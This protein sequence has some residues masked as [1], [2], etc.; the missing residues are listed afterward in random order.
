MAQSPRPGGGPRSELA[1]RLV[2]F[3]TLPFLAALIPLI[4][5]PFVSRAVSLDDWAAMNVGLSVGAFAAAVGL[6]GWNVLGTPLVAMAGSPADQ[7]ALYARSFYIRFSVVVVASAL[8]AVVAVAIS[9]A[10]SWAP[11]AAFAVASALN[12]I[13]LSWYAV[14]VASPRLVL[15][16]EVIPRTIATALALGVVLLTGQVVWY[17]L[18]LCASVVVGVLA[19]HLDLDRR[20]LPHWP[21]WTTLR[22]DVGDMRHAWGVESV[23]SLYAN[24]PLPIA[25]IVASPVAAAA[26]ASNDKIYRYGILGVGAAGN[27]LQGWVLETRDDVR[28]RRNLIAIVIMAVIAVIGWA[29]LAIFGPLLS[30]WLFGA[31]KQGDPLAFHFFGIAFIGVTMST[32]LI[33]NILIPA[34][35][36]RPVFVVTLIAA[37]GGVASMIVLG[38][39]FGIAGVAAGFAISEIVTLLACVVLTL[40]VGLHHHEV[41]PTVQPSATEK[42]TDEI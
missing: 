38:T 4:A 20:L 18:L 37:A 14:G 23:G 6:V 19:F 26:F 21:G 15:L 16:Y 24:A 33:R 10:A 13:S 27:A 32:P 3:S 28:R 25:G 30:G 34:R 22:S 5:L 9:P 35:K 36:D 31:D 42:D 17:G 8:S 1:K 11:A 41:A 29:V 2:G 40:R 7:R 39:T 12:G